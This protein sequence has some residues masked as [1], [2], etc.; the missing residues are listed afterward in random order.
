MA[1]RRAVPG[2]A[3]LPTGRVL[4]AGGVIPT[5]GATAS[6]ELFE[7][8]PEAVAAG[9]GFGAQTVSQPS[10]AQLLVLS[11][12]GAQ[13]LSIA[14][15]SMT[16]TNT[17][18]FAITADACS[19]RTLAFEQSCTIAVHFTPSSAG[20]RSASIALHDNEANPVSIALSGTGVAPGAGPPGATGPIGPAG[21][22]GAPGQIELVTC[23]TVTVKVHGRRVTR[24]KCQ[25]K[26][27][28][29]TATFTSALAKATLSR[30]GV[31]YATGTASLTRLVLRARR[32]VKPGRYLLTL[33]SGPRGARATTRREITVG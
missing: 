5:A 30:R 2:A 24:H 12:V 11:D 6:A 23:K 18:D 15:T 31:V 17:G 32:A 21:P 26:L 25:T 22:R 28:S 4:I 3:L 33:T 10:E 8:A 29:G 14:G 9:G 13:S 27:I 16:G 7:S 20:P 19:G 1:M